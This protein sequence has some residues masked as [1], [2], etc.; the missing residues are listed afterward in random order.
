M[1]E[2]QVP[3]ADFYGILVAK[4]DLAAGDRFHWTKPAYEL[5]A[6]DAAGRVAEALGLALPRACRLPLQNSGPAV[7][8]SSIA[9]HGVARRLDRRKHD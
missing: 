8:P 6:R 9:W 1:Q 4:L 3:I 2:N 5:L 7:I